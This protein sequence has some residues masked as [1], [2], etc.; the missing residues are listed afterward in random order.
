MVDKVGDCVGAGNPFPGNQIPAGCID[1]IAAK[2][3][4]LVPPPNSTRTSGAVNIGNFILVRDLQDDSNHYIGHLDWSPTNSDTVGV[5]YT[6]VQRFSLVPGAVG[7]LL[8]R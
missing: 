5:R 7:G 1:P 2:I 6:N 4:A 3:L 8:D